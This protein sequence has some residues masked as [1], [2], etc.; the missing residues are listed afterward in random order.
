VGP[1]GAA[2]SAK[3]TV[4]GTLVALLAF[5]CWLGAPTQRGGADTVGSLQGQIAA[6]EAQITATAARIHALAQQYTQASLA[7][8]NLAQQVAADNQRVAALKQQVAS[9]LSALRQEA[10]FSYTGGTLSGLNLNTQTGGTDPSVRAE[11]LKIA[12]GDVT[13]TVD[14]YHLEQRQLAGAEALLRQQEGQVQDQA[15]AAG[16]ARQ[17]ALAAASTAEGQLNQLQAELVQAQQAA[18]QAAAQQAAQA[19]A[20]RPVA[21]GAPLSGGL[22]TTVQ[23][24]VSPPPPAPAVSGGGGAGGVWLALRECESSDN[25]ATNTGNGFYGAYQFTQ[26]TWTALGYPGRP[27]LEPPAMQDAAAQKDQ[28]LNGWGQWPACSAALGL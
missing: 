12:S 18:A 3:E 16:K 11:Y 17:A 22:M 24:L 27:D 1:V 13:D 19:A 26:T 25:Y 2:R 23:N 20:A 9:A 28:A 5:A 14:Q 21:Q 6:K 15:E 4:V 7:A 10:I 8:S